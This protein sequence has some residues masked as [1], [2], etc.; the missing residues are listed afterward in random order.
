MRGYPSHNEADQAICHGFCREHIV[1]IE[2]A[3]LT[4]FE[5]SLD[6]EGHDQADPDEGDLEDILRA[7]SLFGRFGHVVGFY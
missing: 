5:D 3:E 1:A 7:E 2:L 4:E 6:A